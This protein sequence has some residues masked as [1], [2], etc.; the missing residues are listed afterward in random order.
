MKQRPARRERAL[1]FHW[2][3]AIAVAAVGWIAPAAWSAELSSASYT[4]QGAHTSSGGIGPDPAAGSGTP[5]SV[6]SAGQASAPRITLSS[7]GGTVA[8]AGL[9]PIVAGALPGLDADLDGVAA[10]SGLGDNCPSQA[11]ADQANFD[12]DAAGDVCDADDDNDGLL[13][14]VETDTG[15][16]VSAGDTG[17][18]PFNSDSDGDGFDDG[19]EV[20]Q[21]SDPNDAGSVP[22]G[23]PVPSMNAWLRA[24][25]VLCMAFAACGFSARARRL[26]GVA[27]GSMPPR[28][29]PER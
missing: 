1:G 10:L 8:A 27:Q 12:G 21:G 22:G 7:D 18:D 17:S 3:V 15:V 6:G 26:P 29:P 28:R 16:F 5:T 24:L 20:A 25:L 19:L 13:D 2:A 23:A 9:Y 11:N 4:I 14:T